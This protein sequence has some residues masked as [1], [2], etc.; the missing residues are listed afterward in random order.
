MTKTVA[1]QTVG[2]KRK[3]MGVSAAHY[4]WKNPYA[5]N[6]RRLGFPMLHVGAPRNH[7][8]SQSLMSTSGLHPHTPR[9]EVGMRP[10]HPR[11]TRHVA[12]DIHWRS[13]PKGCFLVHD[14]SLFLTVGSGSSHPSG[15][16][17]RGWEW[18]WP[19]GQSS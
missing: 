6:S 19:Q 3:W 14:D 10:L 7:L 11:G 9:A 18:G 4:L 16:Q 17:P 13:S 2:S 15:V 1:L 8:E 12:G 5:R